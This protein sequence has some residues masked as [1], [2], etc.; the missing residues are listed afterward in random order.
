MKRKYILEAAGLLAA[1]ALIG[2]LGCN[3]T[4]VVSGINPTSGPEKG[5]NTV[6]ITGK[7]FK[8]GAQVDFGGKLI[9]ANVQ[10]KTTITV[11]AP[12]GDVGTVN[13]T[14]VNPK[15]KRAKETVQYTYLDTTPPTV[16]SV[17]PADG[18]V[19]QQGT[20]Y[21]DAVQTGINTV[22][23]TFSEPIQRANIRVSWQKLP[24]AINPEGSGEVSGSVSV[25][26]NTATFTASSDLLS[27]RQYTVTIEGT[28]TAGNTSAPQTVRFSIA[29]PKRVHYYTVKPG[30]TLESIA[31]R[32]DT[33]DSTDRAIIRK[34][35]DVNDDYHEL[36]PMRPQA[37]LRLVLHW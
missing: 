13:V 17:T 1:V 36:N 5:G 23:V 15:N 32:P 2:L 18:T 22:R 21:Q 29:T 3:P 31:A 12:P 34:I 20:D 8:K 26:G 28:D 33:Y 14:V 9:A 24:D 10:D 4:P 6:T 27:A 35:V 16:Q 25:S 11:T 19:F 37:G 7:K 30:D